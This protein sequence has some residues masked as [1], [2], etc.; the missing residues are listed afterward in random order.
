[1]TEVVGMRLKYGTR[2]TAFLFILVAAC[3]DG[4]GGNGSDSGTDAGSDTDSDADID[5]DTDG[6]VDT[7]TVTDP[8]TE[9]YPEPGFPEDMGCGIDLDGGIDTDSCDGVDAG[10]SAD[11]VRYVDI[12]VAASGDGL[13][14]ASA[15]KTVQEGI[16]DAYA[17]M[18]PC[19]TCQIW[20]AEGTY[21]IFVDGVDDT[22]EVKPGMELYGG[23]DGTE[24]SLD[25]RDWDA[26]VA[27]L[28][29]HE[30]EDS[31]NRVEHVVTTLGRNTLD[32]LVVTGGEVEGWG[33][34]IAIEDG[35]F[36]LRHCT[37]KDNTSF[38]EGSV[39]IVS[40]YYQ[41][42][43]SITDCRFENSSGVGVGGGRLS[44]EDSVFFHDGLVFGAVDEGIVRNCQFIQGWIE[45]N[46]SNGVLID[47]VSFG[48]DDSEC[49]GI[50]VKNVSDVCVINSYLAGCRTALVSEYLSTIHVDNTVFVGNS[51]ADWGG[52]AD[53]RGPGLST[54]TDC[55]F[56]DNYAGAYGSA[57]SG[58]NVAVDHC[59]FLNNNLDNIG[60]VGGRVRMRDSI[61]SMDKL[62]ACDGSRVSSSVMAGSSV[63][64]NGDNVF[65]D[66]VV[67]GSGAH[68]NFA[69]GEIWEPDDACDFDYSEP[70]LRRTTLAGS[71]FSGVQVGEW[72][73]AVHVR[74]SLL[75][76]NG[77]FGGPGTVKYSL[78]PDDD[79]GEGNIS[80]DPMFNG[81]SASTGTWTDSYF[82]EGL[83]QTELTDD[84]ASWE[85]G[86]LA[87]KF[88]MISPAIKVAAPIA[89][90]TAT[91]IW[92]WGNTMAYTAPGS[93]YEI[94][95]LHLQSGSPA[96]DSGYGSNVSDLDIEGNPRYDDPSAANA[97]D[98][99][100]STDCVEYVDMGAY[101]RQL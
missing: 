28:D 15:F 38:G 37:V 55:I 29:G 17:T 70:I 85:P 78:L 86:E 42:D 33:A 87:G 72:C 51:S 60:G 32:G 45:V 43:I 67:V 81:Y 2:L 74:G 90:N 41:G 94:I 91:T 57:L 92:A 4:G 46:G 47:S 24:T 12:D 49:G 8:D 6:D 77:G 99:G 34:G 83:F 73:D 84:S 13:S 21:Y 69:C 71:I 75:W 62:V 35:P 101:E 7:D 3:S 80:V 22:V 1:M 97:Y 82:D 53:V 50:S 89:D 40:P 48:A 66:T 63:I 76:D 26:H 25:E 10:T 23:F 9:G 64:S 58:V 19:D 59:F 52:A 96:I 11:C 88:V 14:W 56:Y 27:T 100:T 93:L 31:E 39:T 16:D 54:F 5:S 36:S 44:V 20:V 61:F 18:G 95:D 79:P 68:S 65:E 30:Y 98:C